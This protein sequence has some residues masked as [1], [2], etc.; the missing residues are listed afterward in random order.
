MARAVQRYM[1]LGVCDQYFAIYRSRSEVNPAA[2][3]HGHFRYCRLQ[4]YYSRSI[5]RRPSNS[6]TT[7][8]PTSRAIQWCIVLL[9]CGHC[10]VSYAPITVIF[11]CLGRLGGTWGTPYIQNQPSG[12]MGLDV[13]SHSPPAPPLP[14]TRP[15]VAWLWRYQYQ[16]V[17]LGP[18]TDILSVNYI[19]RT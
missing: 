2:A 1:G 17:G 19:S 14:P 9:V 16:V 13:S 15:P 5:R 6:Y 3:A 4:A 18:F 11:P 12:H 10:I 8:H 7:G